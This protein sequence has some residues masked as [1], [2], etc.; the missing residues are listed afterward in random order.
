M[1]RPRRGFDQHLDVAVIITISADGSGLVL[2][3]EPTP[4][5]IESI[6]PD[7][8]YDEPSTP[9]AMLPDGDRFVIPSGPYAGGKGYFVRND[10]GDIAGLHVSSRYVPRVENST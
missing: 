8:D 2:D 5:I 3:S 1:R 7:A 10:A 6:G 4:E 9:M